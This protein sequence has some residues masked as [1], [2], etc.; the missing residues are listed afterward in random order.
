LRR[1]PLLLLLLLLLLCMAP[2]HLCLHSSLPV[3]QG[4]S[5]IVWWQQV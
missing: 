5:S 4:S 3:I 1:R 2:Q